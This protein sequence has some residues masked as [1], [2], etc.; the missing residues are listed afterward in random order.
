MRKRTFKLDS[1]EKLPFWYNCIIP[2]V[3]GLIG[4]IVS[5]Q[6]S[7]E[8]TESIIISLLLG[9]F[10]SQMQ[11][12]YLNSNEFLKIK[13]KQKKTNK[14]ID[15]I[16]VCSELYDKMKKIPHPYFHRIAR[17]KL[18]SFLAAN[19]ELFKGT[20]RTI[21]NAEES[22]IP[23]GLEYTCDG[24]TLKMTSSMWNYRDTAWNK[25]YLELQKKIIKEKSVSIQRIFFILPG[26]FEKI[27]PEMKAQHDVGI[28]V[29][30][31]YMDNQ[32]I[33]KEWF[34]EDYLIQDDKLL[35]EAVTPADTENPQNF[36]ELNEQIITI[37][38]AKVKEKIKRFSRLLERAEKF[39][40]I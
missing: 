30:Y 12:S 37:D 22:F 18:D 36:V 35:G 3:F 29:Y 19:N 34:K 25:K 11:Q 27:K 2:L 4:F 10:S 8:I 16:A 32:H 9:I 28:E 23:N 21:Y 5:T 6:S 39:E 15:E 40:S 33:S 24:G 38:S 31:I 1:K 13:S 17:D 20:H 26:D 14:K 7:F